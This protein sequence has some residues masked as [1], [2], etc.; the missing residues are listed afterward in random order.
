MDANHGNGTWLE[1]SV[2]VIKFIW[3]PE[4]CS[5]SLR[6]YIKKSMYPDRRKVKK[7][8]GYICLA[9][10]DQKKEKPGMKAPSWP[11]CSRAFLEQLLKLK[12]SIWLCREG[13]P[14]PLHS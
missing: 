2:N 13:T 6:R 7:T 14:V 1:F 10:S 9:L 11:R 4:Y 12:L 5:A 8:G 3:I